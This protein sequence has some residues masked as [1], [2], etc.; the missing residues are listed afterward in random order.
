MFDLISEETERPLRERSLRSRV[1]AILAH[2][3]AIT[4]LVV[5]TLFRVATVQPQLRTTLAF[6][7]TPAVLPS[8]PPPPPPAVA[9]HAPHDAPAAK[10]PAGVVE[11]PA[12]SADASSAVQQE[13]TGTSH[14]EAAAGLESGVEGG[15]TGGVVGG[16]VE[17]I[18]AP[19]APAPPPPAPTSSAAP[20]RVGG[21]IK[22]P[23]LLHRVEPVYSALAA[24]THL[25]GIVILE[26]VVDA[27][28]G[29]ESVRVVRSA[30]ALLDNAASD[31]LKQWK[32]SA[33]VLNGIPTPFVVTVTF[34]FSLA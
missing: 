26:A 31:A 25:G 30:G 4:A 29:V 24:A 21:P 32:Y 23:G 7:V 28:G 11:Q 2:A 22:T 20:V 15:V 3:A 8:L 27:S 33:L 9:S 6:V 10:E 34:R 5:V 12:I 18:G 1:A 19:V 17:G 16:I 14:V 13:H